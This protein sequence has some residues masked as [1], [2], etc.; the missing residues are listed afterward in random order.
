M[1]VPEGIGGR[2]GVIPWFQAT[3]VGKD[4]ERRETPMVRLCVSNHLYLSDF[5]GGFRKITSPYDGLIKELEEEVPSWKDEILVQLRHPSTFI[6]ALEQCAARPGVKDPIPLQ[7]LLFPHVSAQRLEQAH[8]QPTDE[9]RAVMVRTLAQFH[10]MVDYRPTIASSGIRMYHL[11]RRHEV[12]GQALEQLFSARVQKVEYQ[13]EDLVDE[14]VEVVLKNG[15]STAT[16]QELVRNN[17]NFSR[18]RTIAWSMREK[19][20]LQQMARTTRNGANRRNTT[21]H[22]K[23]YSNN[24]NQ[25]K[26]N[27]KRN[28]R[29]FVSL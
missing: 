10:E 7:F 5:G 6:L 15:V 17:S 19:Y 13:E 24:Q 21:V 8:F 25:T 18:N 12:L 2:V 14:K 3:V 27:T 20:A 26:W 22:R 4:G 29:G 23:G 9:V 16:F 1:S 28:R 11:F